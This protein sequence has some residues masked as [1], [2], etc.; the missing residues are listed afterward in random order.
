M[1]RQK[2]IAADGPCG[3]SAMC[4]AV[5]WCCTC[6]PPP[7]QT[8]S[9]AD[10]LLPSFHGP[11]IVSLHAGVCSQ[12]CYLFL[13]ST[14][15]TEKIPGVI[16]S[17]SFLLYQLQTL[18]KWLTLWAVSQSVVCCILLLLYLGSFTV[19]LCFNRL[20]KDVSFS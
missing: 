1:W 10:L 14:P 19:Q 12:S 17:S 11:V 2:L 16:F 7:P 4:G 6:M 8:S 13:Y 5:V 9:H 18:G 20:L 15:D 3:F